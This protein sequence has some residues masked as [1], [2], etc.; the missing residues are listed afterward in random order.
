MQVALY[1]F[2]NCYHLANWLANQE[3]QYNFENTFHNGYQV[4]SLHPLYFQ[5]YSLDTSQGEEF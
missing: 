5:M 2:Q 4:L 3:A 1:V